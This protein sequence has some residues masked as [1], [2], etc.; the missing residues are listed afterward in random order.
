M[1]DPPK[2][3]LLLKIDAS[4]SLRDFWESTE[5]IDNQH[6]HG[7]LDSAWSST[8]GKKEGIFVYY[9]LYYKCS[10]NYSKQK[11]PLFCLM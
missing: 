1:Y 6:K 5:T 10:T 3:A 11:Y 8:S 7:N 9:N 2:D 4:G